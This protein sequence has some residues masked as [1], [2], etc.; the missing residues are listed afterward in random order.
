MSD[1]DIELAKITGEYEIGATITSSLQ[2]CPSPECT[3][4]GCATA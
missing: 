1:L 3:N 4:L 2:T